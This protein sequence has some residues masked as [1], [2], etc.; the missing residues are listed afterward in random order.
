[1]GSR[2]VPR[3]PRHGCELAA[4]TRLE[5]RT[6]AEADKYAHGWA[7]PD[8]TTGNAY[9]YQRDR[10]NGQPLIRGRPTVMLRA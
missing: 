3:R 5:T 7:L 1:M 8:G 2:I 6:V 10:T 4:I 9:E